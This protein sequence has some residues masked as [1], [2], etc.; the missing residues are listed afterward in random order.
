MTDW[1]TPFQESEALLAVIADDEDRA[2]E[3]LAEMSPTERDT[4]RV[5]ATRLASLAW[6]WCSRC[7]Q[8]IRP[9]QQTGN[10]MGSS[11]LYHH[12]TCPEG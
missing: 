9:G 7:E 1:Q 6:K 3:I 10:R 5:Q 4:L 8:P 11:A 12:P 2:M